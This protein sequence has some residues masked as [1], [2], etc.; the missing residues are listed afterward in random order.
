MVRQDSAPFESALLR[1][2]EPTAIGSSPRARMQFF[3]APLPSMAVAS[4]SLRADQQPVSDR[5]TS[6]IAVTIP[7]FKALL[8]LSFANATC[9]PGHGRTEQVS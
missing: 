9:A 5:H 4:E 6:N 2:H 8:G 1:T 7:N 3:R